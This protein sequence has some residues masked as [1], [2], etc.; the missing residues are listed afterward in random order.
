MSIVGS[1]STLILRMKSRVG[2]DGVGTHVR[3]DTGVGVSIVGINV[4]SMEMHVN[5]GHGYK[6]GG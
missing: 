2:I 1:L 5:V 3:L 6:C 4:V